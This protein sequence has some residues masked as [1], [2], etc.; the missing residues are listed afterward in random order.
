MC[1]VS[2]VNGTELLE[3]PFK[4][5]AGLMHSHSDHQRLKVHLTPPDQ[6]EFSGTTIGAGDFSKLAALLD[7]SFSSRLNKQVELIRGA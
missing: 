4:G 3:R 6:V 1:H 7:V 5:R 2:R